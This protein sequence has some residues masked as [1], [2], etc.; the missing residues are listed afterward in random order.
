M[1]PDE[2]EI[3]GPDYGGPVRVWVEYYPLGGVKE[4]KPYPDGPIDGWACKGRLAP[5]PLTWPNAKAAYTW[6]KEHEFDT[7][8]GD[9]G[10]IIPKHTVIKAE[11][12]YRPPCPKCGAPGELWGGGFA[13]A[14]RCES[15]DKNFEMSPSWDTYRD[16]SGSDWEISKHIG[17]SVEKP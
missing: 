6:I 3:A 12:K 9:D 4:Y 10:Y 8:Y 15:C 17:L 14:V 2:S 5:E 11:E 13:Q 16:M 1:K 7:Y